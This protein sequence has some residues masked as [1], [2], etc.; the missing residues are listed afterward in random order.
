LKI[1]TNRLEIIAIDGNNVQSPL[2]H[3][4]SE[5]KKHINRYLDQLK[6]D[7]QLLGWGVWIVI[8]KDTNEAVGDIGFKGKP[9]NHTVEVG[10]GFIPTARNKGYATESVKAL[11][12]WAF[13][14]DLVDRIVAEC[15][16]GNQPSIR[17]LEKL[18]MRRTGLHNEMYT[19]ELLRG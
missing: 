1:D 18:G 16:T 4:Y 14:T 8:A 17:V 5:N 6:G 15:L 13:S 7:P 10:Y 3:P 2:I 11:V 12:D 9:T 19:W